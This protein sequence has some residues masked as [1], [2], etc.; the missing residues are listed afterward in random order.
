MDAISRKRTGTVSHLA[1]T[2]NGTVGIEPIELSFDPGSFRDRTARV[3]Y[4]NGQVFRT[5]SAESQATWRRISGESFF[6]SLMAMNEI[7]QT[8]EASPSELHRFALPAGVDAVLRHER[9]PF[10]SYPCEWSFS[11]L[12]EAALLHLRILEQSVRGGYILKDASPF[13]VQFRGA[14]PVF[15]D[16]GSFVELAPGEPW[17]AYRQFC[18]LMLFPL[19][20]Q[21]YRGVNFQPIL[22]GQLEGIPARQFLQWMR[23]RDLFRP[24]V[25]TNGWLQ[26]AL[27]R[28]TE[29]LPSSTV[30]DLQSSGFNSSLILRLLAKLTHLIEGLRWVPRQTQWMNYNASLPHVAD[31]GQAKS[32]FVRKVCES[33]R[34]NLIWDL[35]CNDGR[36]SL[37]ASKYATTVVAMDQDHACIERLK[38]SLHPGDANILPI[39]VELSNPSP[40]LGWR[41]RERKRLED[42]GRPE[43]VLCLGLVH[44]LVLAANIPLADV[45]DWL[46]SLGGEVILEFPSKQDAM[47]QSLLRN[48]RD[49]YQDYSLASLETELCRHFEI[50]LREDLPSGARTLFHVVTKVPSADPL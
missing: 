16:I 29:G 24:G 14:K 38:Q 35:G 26:A 9:I 37:I 7:I 30:R 8:D 40:A 1:V 11:M 20:L 33:A 34:R 47:V 27:E 2:G 10:I 17:S 31:D 42:R 25:F 13:N 3:F 6:Q 48:K 39:C 23:F 15:I 43:L 4:A 45:I 36:Y 50:R 18:E 19:L 46:A 32:D 41:G 28:R 22:R 44:H 21:A 49:Q 12:R 5:L